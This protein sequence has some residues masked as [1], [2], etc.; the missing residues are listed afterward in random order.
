MVMSCVSR[1][2]VYNNKKQVDNLDLNKIPGR[3]RLVEF[4]GFIYQGQPFGPAQYICDDPPRDT[5]Y[6]YI[7]GIERLEHPDHFSRFTYG[8]TDNG[9]GVGHWPGRYNTPA[10]CQPFTG[11]DPDNM[12]PSRFY[13]TNPL[14][15][16]LCS[17]GTATGK[18]FS[19]T[20]SPAY[21]AAKKY[22]GLKSKYVGSC[23]KC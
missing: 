6:N 23:K 3:D 4:P 20:E 10:I 11:K 7:Y 12:A 9:Y 22:M 2:V 18:C 21:V 19:N 13:P 16:S 1:Y 5:N 8:V 15:L 14:E 17:D